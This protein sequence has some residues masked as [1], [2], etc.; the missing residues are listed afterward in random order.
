[1]KGFRYYFSGALFVVLCLLDAFFG[2]MLLVAF[3]QSVEMVI[4]T[5]VF[6]LPLLFVTKKFYSWHKKIEPKSKRVIPGQSKFFEDEN[7]EP[8]W[9]SAENKTEF[10]TSQKTKGGYAMN[11]CKMKVTLAGD[12]GYDYDA[13]IEIKSSMLFIRCSCPAG[14][15]STRCKH[16][17]SLINGD[18]SRLKDKNEKD[19]VS[20]LFSSLKIKPKDETLKNE[21]ENIEKQEKELKERKKALKKQMDRLFFEG[22]PV[23]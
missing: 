10:Q 6:L 1:M 3:S 9:V 11:D 21:I 5:I 2:L 22:I 14:M 23:E 15:S 12:S 20:Q 19:K 8:L 4:G 18:F 13:D 7:D 17:L 16:A